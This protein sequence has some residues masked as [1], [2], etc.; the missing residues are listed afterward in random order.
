MIWT[1][2]CGITR[3]EDAL[4]AAQWGA[5]ALGFVMWQGSPRRIAP[6]AAAQIVRRLPAGL[7]TVG[8][9]VNASAEEIAAAVEE[10]GLTM[11][12]LH[13]D[14]PASLVSELSWP[15]LRAVSVERV[16]SI[17]ATWPADITVLL[18]AHDPVVRGGTGR[19]IDWSA[20]AAVA[21]QRRTVLA[22]GL[23]PGNV[24]DAIRA[25]RPFGVDV[26]SGV[27]ARPG[28]KDPDKLR[29][30]LTQVAEESDG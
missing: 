15:L 20:A 18:D 2:V 14:E 29:S 21:A 1:K 22:G 7:T 4:A 28:V 24:R 6:A 25:V 12:Q 17:L 26:S 30:F 23:T 27:E 10:A 5:A 9:F 8:V 16:D 3:A 13:G 11:V 19:T